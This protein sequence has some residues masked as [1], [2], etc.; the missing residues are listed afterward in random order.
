MLSKKIEL[1]TP[2]FTFGISSKVNI[3]RKN[4]ETIIDLS[5]GEPDFTTPVSG[6]EKALEAINLNMTKYDLVPGLLPLR[7]AICQKLSTENQVNYLP[8]EIVASSGAKNAITNAL[9]AVLDP[10]DEVLVPSPYWT[11]YPE[12]IKLCHGHPVVVKTEKANDYKLTVEQLHKAVTNKTKLLLINNPSNPTGSVYSKEE[13]L[14]LIDY[15]VSHNILILADEI[16]EKIHFEETFTSIP[17]ISEEAKNITILVNGFSKSAAMTGWRLGYTASN[18]KIA[19]SISTIQGHL[20]SHPSTIAQWAGLGALES[21]EDEMQQM[22]KTYKRRRDQLIPMLENL[23]KVDFV[24]PKGAFYLFLDLSQ[25]KHAFKEEHSFSIALCDRFLSEYKVAVV[26]GIAFGNDDC[27]RISYATKIEW[28]MEG[29]N[30]L[31]SFLESLDN[32]K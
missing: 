22:V 19:A 6:K 23:P 31:K 5:I 29:L 16:Y 1:I 17:S 24:N 9:M 11:S 12:M 26:P 4:G 2:S 14:P 15:C 30:R 25:Y 3:L 32:A 7:E 10:G 27:I 21:G 18:A 28:V 8:S 20:T 13:L